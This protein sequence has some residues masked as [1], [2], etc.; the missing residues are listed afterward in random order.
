MNEIVVGVDES[1]TAAAALRWAVDHGRRHGAVVT[2]V[3]A[4][5]YLDQHELDPDAPFDSEFGNAQA[6]DLLHAVTERALGGVDAVGERVV[7]DHPGRALVETSRGAS[8]L[9]V[10]A[11]GL[12]GF[13]GLL[14]GSVSRYVLHHASC[15]VA[16]IRGH[17]LAPDA[18]L[19]VGVD[20]SDTATQ[21]LR[22][23]IDDGRARAAAVIAVHAWRPS[24]TVEGFGGGY[25]DL[26]ALRSSS[27]DLLDAQ[28]DA[29]DASGLPVPIERRLVDDTAAQGLLAAAG[30]DALLVVGSRGR[31]AV[32]RLVLG[33]VSDQVVHHARGP[34][35]VVGGA[36]SEG[37]AAS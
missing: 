23:A 36:P 17:E 16:V 19:V 14:L 7:C 4:W 31:G 9:V 12:G 25:L 21:A 18:P 29:V 22:W 35:I 5:S 15:P 2:A 33:S 26:A 34:V 37:V 30:D 24:P 3:L 11:R 6:A 28:V 13:T 20:G 10:G 27:Q 32:A 8:L 1:P